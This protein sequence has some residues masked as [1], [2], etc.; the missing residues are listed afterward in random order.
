M[1]RSFGN[2]NMVATLIA[3]QASAATNR[4]GF[5]ALYQAVEGSR[6]KV[7]AQKP[8]E[9]EPAPWIPDPKTGYYRPENAADEIDLAELRAML[10]KPIKINKN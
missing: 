2:V 10:L 3:K 1:A 5:A 4:R 9:K 7:M 6:K 8:T